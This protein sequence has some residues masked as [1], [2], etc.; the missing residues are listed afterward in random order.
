MFFWLA[1]LAGLALAFWAALRAGLYETVALFV[2]IVVA[3]YL[4]LF[5]T[6]TLVGVIPAA[7][8]V[9]HGGLIAV[10]VVAVAT[11]L[12]LHVLCFSMLTGQFKVSFPKLLDGPLA[13][14]LGFFAGFLVIAFLTTL[15]AFVPGPGSSG[16]LVGN[17]D[18]TVHRSYLCWW[19][20]RVHALVGSAASAHPTLD[21]L[22]LLRQI[23]TG[24][25]AAKRL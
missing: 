15:L 12:V 21:N 11:F 23:E 4:A 22:D 24:E 18:Q 9:P 3:V 17:N 13:A 16:S 25:P 10:A 2:N 1:V 19:C 7:A 14:G 8:D 20:D 6:P 5:V